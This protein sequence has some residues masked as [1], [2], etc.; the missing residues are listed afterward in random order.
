MK[1]IAIIACMIISGYFAWSETKSTVLRIV[2]TLIGGFV[3][4]I[5]GAQF[6]EGVESMVA[7]NNL[8][9]NAELDI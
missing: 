4:L 7:F 2:A 3:G 1:V 8:P 6:D 9:P 5:I